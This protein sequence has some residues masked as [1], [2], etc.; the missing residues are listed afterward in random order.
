[1]RLQ[2]IAYETPLSIKNQNP[3]YKG[4]IL[5]IS[6]IENIV[7]ENISFGKFNIFLSK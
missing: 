3:F 2:Q 4:I 6:T 7:I 1:M 5:S